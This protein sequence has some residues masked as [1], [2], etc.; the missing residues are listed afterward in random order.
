LTRPS[1]ANDNFKS[2]ELLLFYLSPLLTVIKIL[3]IETWEKYRF[4]RKLC[5]VQAGLCCAVLEAGEMNGKEKAMQLSSELSSIH[6]AL[7]H[8]N[9]FHLAICLLCQAGKIYVYMCE[10]HE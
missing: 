9:L 6:T 7:P 4:S 3:Y 10:V 2:S 5:I 1:L 8:G